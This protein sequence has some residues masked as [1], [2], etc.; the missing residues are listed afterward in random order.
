ME[1]KISKIHVLTFAE[2][3]DVITEDAALS[4]FKSLFLL[5]SELDIYYIHMSVQSSQLYC[6]IDNENN[7]S[8]SA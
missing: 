3:E 4:R 2:S 5:Q 7:L 1:I 6:M 8:T